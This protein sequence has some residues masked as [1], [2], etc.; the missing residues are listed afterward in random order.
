[1]E[2][3]VLANQTRDRYIYFDDNRRMSV[4]TDINQAEVFFESVKAYNVLDNQMPKKRRDAWIVIEKEPQPPKEPEPA[5]TSKPQ[6]FR[7]DLDFSQGGE[8]FDW[9]TLV[10]NITGSYRGIFDYKE[11][12]QKELT[13][14]EAELCDIEHAIEFFNYNA[15]DGYKMY[16]M[17]H[18]CRVRRRG[19]KDDLRKANAILG[20]SY[21]QIVS[22]EIDKTFDEVENQTYEPRILPELFERKKP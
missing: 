19:I 12:L 15:S 10:D 17:L 22:G 1:M 13:K 8:V 6:R 18:D 21:E 5:A 4:T 9:D 20:M 3:F 14:V 16:K 11:F 2:G 7:A